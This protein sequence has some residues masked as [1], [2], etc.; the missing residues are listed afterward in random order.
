MISAATSSGDLV[1]VST[2]GS[3][4]SLDELLS[5]D[6]PELFEEDELLLLLPELEL[7]VLTSVFLLLK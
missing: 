7:L 6:E 3:F 4:D 5:F 2:S 1:S